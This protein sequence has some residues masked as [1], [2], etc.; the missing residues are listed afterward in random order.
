MTPRTK[1]VV[2]ENTTYQIGS[3]SPRDGSWIAAQFNMRGL[4]VQLETGDAKP[5]SEKDLGISL[6]AILSQLPEETFNRIQTKCLNVIKRY[7]DNAGQRVPMPLQMAD[8]RFIP[9]ELDLVTLTAL[10]ISGL[11][12]NLYCFFAPGALKTLLVVFPDLSTPE[13]IPT[14][15]GQSSQT[16]GV[17]AK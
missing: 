15:S 6:A 4:L 11:V 17:T 13:S 14:S 10:T 2:I 8:G 12:F 9:P 1:D 3:F 5:I 7:E 16:T